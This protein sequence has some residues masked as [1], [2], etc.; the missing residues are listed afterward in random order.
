MRPF[1]SGHVAN[2]MA[3]EVIALL[4]SLLMAPESNAAQIWT[5]TAE[6]VS[7]GRTHNL[8]SLFHPVLVVVVVF[9]KPSLSFW[10]FWK[11]ARASSSLGFQNA[12]CLGWFGLRGVPSIWWAL[13]RSSFS[14]LPLPPQDCVTQG[15]M[16]GVS[17]FCAANWRNASQHLT[18]VRKF[19]IFG[20]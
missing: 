8:T 12:S 17:L 3:A 1:I 4:H 13:I 19:Q 5:T 6:K 11:R 15:G 9:W 14:I 16:G 2:S 10:G 7:G 18:L 20:G